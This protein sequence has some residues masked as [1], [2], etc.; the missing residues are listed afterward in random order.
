ML[1]LSDATRTSQ[2]AIIAHQADLCWRCTQTNRT[3]TFIE[4][5]TSYHSTFASCALPCAFIL[6]SNTWDENQ[7][8][9][10]IGK[11]VKR[12]QHHG[13]L[14]LKAVGSVNGDPGPEW[15]SSDCDWSKVR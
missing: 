12:N 15:E 8:Q 3:G 4:S 6:I 10:K 5:R 13:I 2:L 9:P 1:S 14:L 7:V 11:L